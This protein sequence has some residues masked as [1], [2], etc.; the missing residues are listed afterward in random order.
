MR[1]IHLVALAAFTIALT[2]TA[3]TFWSKR[4]AIEK[5]ELNEPIGDD[6]EEMLKRKARYFELIHRARPGTDWRAIETANREMLAEIQEQRLLSP[7]RVMESFAGG[8]ITATWT[9]R[10]SKN[11]AGNV[12]AVDYVPSTN[13]LY[14]VSDAGTLWQGDPDAGNWVVLNQTKKLRNDVIDVFPNGSGGQRIMVAE[15]EA[16]WYSDNNGASFTQSTGISFP[17]G[18]GGNYV[19]AI[20]ALNDAGNTVYCL[21]RPWDPT[22]WSPRFWLYRSTNRGV[23]FTQI[24]TF[25]FGD[26]NLLSLYSPYNSTEL[27]ALSLQSATTQTT[28]YT[29]SGATVSTLNTN[30][31]LPVNV[32]CVLKGFK[33]GG[34]VNFYALAGNN[35]VYK[36]INSGATWTLQSNLPENS[37]NRLA[38]SLSDENRVSYGGVQAYRSSNGGMNWTLVNGWG[39]YYG[40]VSAKLHADIM[41]ITYFRKA[42]NTEF[43]V[44]NTHGGMYISYDH[45]VTNTNVSLTNLNTAQFYDVIT[46]PFN[47]ENIYAGSQDQGAQ[48]GSNAVSQ[49]GALDFIQFFSGDYGHLQLTDNPSRLWIEYP[50]GNVSFYGTPSAIASYTGPNASLAVAG[51]EKP[52]V[53]WMLATANTSNVLKNISKRLTWQLYLTPTVSYRKWSANKSYH[54]PSSPFSRASYPFSLSRDVN[55]EVV[56]KP[57]MGLEVGLSAKYPLTRNLKLTGGLQFN[58]NRYDIKAFAY[59]GEQATINLNGGNGN[60]SVTAWTY[61][62]NYN[63]YKSDWL[64]NFYFSVSAPVGAELRLFGNDKTNFG[65]GGALQPTYILKDRAFL[66]SSDY[67]NYVEMPRLIRHLN[68][69]TSFETFVSYLSRNGKSRWQI[70]PQVR[71]QVLS[72]FQKQYPVKENLFDFG[73]KIGL[74]FNH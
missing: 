12:K 43:A 31:N 58:I 56:H 45:L 64:K 54:G 29:I 19:A 11:V 62:R 48:K 22:P 69:N 57:D 59:S 55:S 42:D 18:W 17:V 68:L 35:K 61:Y 73:L 26:D 8:Y 44:V 49:P 51:T 21:T 4:A 53:E 32:P 1:K 65:I 74:T 38:V 7:N 52:N 25:G 27:Y 40:N 47:N 33:N 67:K 30:T 50:G 39:D 37:W 63:G 60:N 72:S 16:V 3:L 14:L 15:S 36:S 2:I 5:N 28:L 46:D 23:S 20:I 10:G 24:H 6:E 71:Y 13:K 9:E 70:G 34:T 66:I 41:E